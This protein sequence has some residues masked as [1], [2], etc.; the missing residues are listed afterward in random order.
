MDFF[1]FPFFNKTYNITSSI[2]KKFIK[3]ISVISL[4]MFSV[5]F[6]LIYVSFIFFAG[7]EKF[8]PM[9]LVK[10]VDIRNLF[11]SVIH[12]FSSLFAI[13][14]ASFYID[15]NRYDGKIVS[16]AIATIVIFAL[17]LL[18]GWR[19]YL[20]RDLEILIFILT[21]DGVVLSIFMLFLSIL[22]YDV[23]S[24]KTARKYAPCIALRILVI[25]AL[26]L[27]IFSIFVYYNFLSY[28][29]SAVSFLR[30]SAFQTDA[31]VLFS[32]IL[33]NLCLL[34]S[35][36]LMFAIEHKLN[37]MLREFT[38]KVNRSSDDKE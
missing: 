4:V 14:F 2:N 38:Q 17:T 1:K 15:K 35:S 37:I 21:L 22:Q 10:N 24:N 9:V 29:L 3:N 8:V 23:I 26:I 18:L 19:C 6:S 5:L 34:V 13:L 33:A 36:I 25:V 20:A 16:P 12:T 31:L 32:Y 28:F 7:L 30:M 27:F 11:I